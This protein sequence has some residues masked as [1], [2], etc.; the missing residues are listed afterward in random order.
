VIVPKGSKREQVWISVVDENDTDENN[1][2]RLRDAFSKSASGKESKT[3]RTNLDGMLDTIGKTSP[4]KNFK[5]CV[6]KKVSTYQF[7][8]FIFCAYLTVKAN[9]NNNKYPH[10]SGVISK[11]FS[12]KFLTKQQNEP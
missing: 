10:S 3:H 6:L 1:D 5:T 8:A 2:S 7:E 11:S 4:R 12:I 9:L